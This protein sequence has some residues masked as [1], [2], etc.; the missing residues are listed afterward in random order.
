LPDVDYAIFLKI[1]EHNCT[2]FDITYTSNSYKIWSK[3][4]QRFF[5]SVLT[6]SALSSLVIAPVFLS[7]GAASA[8]PIPIK[9]VQMLAMSV[10]V[11]LLVSPAADKTMMTLH[12]VVMLLVV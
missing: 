6:I 10:L 4:M 3:N 2:I 5:K 8:Q 9:K 1:L 7:T 12:S 11:L